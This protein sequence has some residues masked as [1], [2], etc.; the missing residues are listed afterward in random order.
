M[1]EF[2]QRVIEL[3]DM[4]LFLDYWWIWLVI[5]VGLIILAEFNSR[6]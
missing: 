4:Q 6:K 3:P 1:V 5:A 2:F